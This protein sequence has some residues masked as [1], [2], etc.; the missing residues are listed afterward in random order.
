V[1]CVCVLFVCFFSV[2]V[3][4]V[5]V[6]CLFYCIYYYELCVCMCVYVLCLVCGLGVC[7]VCVGC[8]CLC[9]VCVPSV[10]DCVLHECV[11]CVL[12]CVCV[13]S[14]FVRFLYELWQ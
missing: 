10:F 14:V 1:W 9:V 5:Y 2:S 3:L 11:L 8:E 6:V 12:W 4:Y 13:V 7:G